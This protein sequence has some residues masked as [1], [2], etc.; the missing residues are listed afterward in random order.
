[1][2]RPDES[3]KAGGQ[4]M[5]SGLLPDRPPPPPIGEEQHGRSSVC[6]PDVPS[7]PRPKTPSIPASVIFDTLVATAEG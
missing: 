5:L 6:L 7:V 3:G 4:G 2:A 1:M